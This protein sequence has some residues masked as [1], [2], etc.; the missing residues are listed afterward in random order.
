VTRLLLPRELDGVPPELAT[1]LRADASLEP[2]LA[3]YAIQGASERVTFAPCVTFAPQMNAALARI[4]ARDFDPR[5]EAVVRGA[6]AARCASGGAA[7]LVAESREAVEIELDAPEGG[8]VVFARAYLPIWR[9]EIDGRPAPTTPA[10]MAR[11]GVEV[12]AGAKRLR[13]HV[14]RTPLVRGL[15]LAAVGALALTLFVLRARRDPDP[16]AA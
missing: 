1:L 7:R 4:L 6:A 15:A 5:R 14:D 8:V 11:L 16:G 9:A 13:L 10:Q 12:P 2:P 3:I